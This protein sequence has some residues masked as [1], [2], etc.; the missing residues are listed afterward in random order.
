M[1]LEKSS[2]I[3][4]HSDTINRYVSEKYI[5]IQ[6]VALEKSVI[7]YV[8]HG[9]KTIYS[10]D[11]S[12]TVA[13]DGIYYIP[14]GIYHVENLPGDNKLFEEVVFSFSSDQISHLLSYDELRIMRDAIQ[15]ESFSPR[16]HF[17]KAWPM[18]CGFFDTLQAYVDSGLHKRDRKL[19]HIKLCELMCLL[20]NHPNSPFLKPLCYSIDENYNIIQSVVA[21]SVMSPRSMSDIAELCGMSLSKFKFHF[22]LY[23]KSSPHR[24]IIQKRLEYASLYLIT[25]NDTIGAIAQRCQFTNT[26]Y[27]IKRFSSTYGMTPLQY[28]IS[29]YGSRS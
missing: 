1:K 18:L 7:G 16:M 24:W 9:M 23:Y 25:T 20:L 4:P 10:E 6:T 28:R 14:G 3:P 29:H 22:E 8:H 12:W 13:P 5:G 19:E 21:S 17:C 2:L 27:F 15:D 11:K 26:S